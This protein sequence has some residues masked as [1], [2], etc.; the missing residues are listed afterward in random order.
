MASVH[1]SLGLNIFPDHSLF[2]PVITS[3]EYNSLFIIMLGFQVF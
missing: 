1:T 3:T 2:D